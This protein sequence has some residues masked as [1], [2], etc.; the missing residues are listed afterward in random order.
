LKKDLAFVEL[1]LLYLMSSLIGIHATSKSAELASSS[2]STNL[3]LCTP[4]SPFLK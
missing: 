3:V 1:N 4:L 2:H